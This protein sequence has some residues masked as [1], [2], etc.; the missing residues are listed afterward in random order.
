MFK[1]KTVIE[2]QI[3]KYK[4]DLDI[5]T[6]KTFLEERLFEQII[7]DKAMLFSYFNA[8]AD[9][10][11][12]DSKKHRCELFIADIRRVQQD[13]IREPYCGAELNAANSVADVCHLAHFGS[14]IFF[15]LKK[16]IIPDVKRMIEHYET[17]LFN[18]AE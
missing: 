16:I 6:S 13:S 3:E 10:M 11:T 12:N 9:S 14:N 18:E 15:E 7:K 4:I 1:F 2:E 8:W 17:E 5:E